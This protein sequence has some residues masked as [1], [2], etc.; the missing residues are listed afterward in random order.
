M[1]INFSFRALQEEQDA[2]TRHNNHVEMP[3]F[4]NLGFSGGD[5]SDSDGWGHPP[6]PPPDVTLP[7]TQQQGAR[8]QSSTRP[9]RGGAAYQVEYQYR[10]DPSH[11]DEDRYSVI[12]D[13]DVINDDKHKNEGPDN[14]GHEDLKPEPKE[15]EREVVKIVID[16]ASED[17][18]YSDSIALRGSKDVDDSATVVTEEK[19]EGY[20]H[21]MRSMFKNLVEKVEDDADTNDVSITF[22]EPDDTQGDEVRQGQD[23]L[24]KYKP[25]VSNDDHNLEEHNTDVEECDIK[26]SMFVDR[27]IFTESPSPD[28]GKLEGEKK[29]PPTMFIF[30]SLPNDIISLVLSHL[31][32]IH[33]DINSAANKHIW[34]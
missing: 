30:F 23:K 28:P 14:E 1:K 13:S 11:D 15:T 20:R 2:G 3:S 29:L 19:T 5:D 7:A 17:L 4:N 22:P 8:P 6:P 34:Y 24:E 26:E 12:S 31:E 10:E 27:T 9:Q 33:F 18:T 25:E 16:D 21:C 32:V